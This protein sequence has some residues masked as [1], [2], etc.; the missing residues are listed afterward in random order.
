MV[1][2]Q[3]EDF[4]IKEIANAIRAK[5]GK[6][7]EMT[8]D[9]MVTEIGG[10]ETGVPTIDATNV[11]FGSKPIEPDVLHSIG[12]NWF[13]EVV[14]HVQKLAGTSSKMTTADIVYWLGR[15]K[16]TPQGNAESSV[17]LSFDSAASGTK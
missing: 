6:A 2:R 5:T 4:K 17:S 9:Q 14:G 7:E 1:I 15:I 11:S 10:I 13:A 3:I 8:L 12:Y 16:Y